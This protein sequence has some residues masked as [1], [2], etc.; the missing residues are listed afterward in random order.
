MISPFSGNECKEIEYEHEFT[1]R[2][3]KFNVMC[4]RWE[5]PDTG[6]CFSTSEQDDEI[7]FKIIELYLEKHP[8]E[9]EDFKD[10]QKN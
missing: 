8:D 7:F 1:F 3:E 5:C 4:K 2:G 6:Q 9:R 10:L